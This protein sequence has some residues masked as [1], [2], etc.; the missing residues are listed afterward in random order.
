MNSPD[1][2]LKLSYEERMALATLRKSLPRKPELAAALMQ[3]MSKEV[4]NAV[5]KQ[6]AKELND[7]LTV[8]RA[9]SA[10]AKALI[11]LDKTEE[12]QT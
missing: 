4:A 3:G 10:A 5:L 1:T 7:M 6:A 2:Q 8:S 11:A 9:F 12:T